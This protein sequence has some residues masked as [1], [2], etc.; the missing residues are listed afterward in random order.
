VGQGFELEG[1]VEERYWKK[2]GEE[3]L[4]AEKQLMNIGAG[5]RGGE[6]RLRGATNRRGYGERSDQAKQPGRRVVG[7]AERYKID[8]A[9]VMSEPPSVGDVH[10]YTTGFVVPPPPRA[11]FK[12]GKK[13]TWTGQDGDE[14][15]KLLSS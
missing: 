10:R 1:Y 7:L 9:A 6:R 5:I 14:I 11:S 13:F 15:D 4:N 12:R 3:K 2:K 8:V